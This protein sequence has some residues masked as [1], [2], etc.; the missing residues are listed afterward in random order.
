VDDVFRHTAQN[1]DAQQV[2]DQI[3]QLGSWSGEE[4]PLGGAGLSVDWLLR[5]QGIAQLRLVGSFGGQGDW[6]AFFYVPTEA[7]PPGA[8]LPQLHIALV[9]P[10]GK[11][12]LEERFFVLLQRIA[13]LLG[14]LEAE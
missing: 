3:D 4:G 2:I 10:R 12:F 7:V 9:T 14:D 13:D 6:R 8:D 11:L 1:E 5:E